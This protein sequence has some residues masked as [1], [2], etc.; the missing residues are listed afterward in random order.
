MWGT[1]PK[2]RLQPPNQDYPIIHPMAGSDVYKLLW[3]VMLSTH[4]TT[5]ECKDL[6]YKLCKIKRLEEGYVKKCLCNRII[7]V[8]IGCLLFS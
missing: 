2:S 3:G 5:S 1:I 8:H 4:L 6:M 7:G